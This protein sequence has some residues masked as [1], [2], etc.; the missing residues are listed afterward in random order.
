M[1][2]T[3]CRFCDI[4]NNSFLKSNTRDCVPIYNTV[5]LE[6]PNFLVLPALGS[7]IPGYLMIITRSH[8]NSMAY[9]SKDHM[10]ELI[11]LLS[12]LKHILMQTLNITPIIFEHGSAINSTEVAAN[13][14]DHAH[15]HVAP[16]NMTTEMDIL[17]ESQ[18]IKIKDMY[19]IKSFMGNPY[20]LYINE[21]NYFISHEVTLE[22]QFMRKW[23]AKEAGSAPMWD[24]REYEFLENVNYTISIL[25]NKL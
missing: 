20:F 21:N 10:D 16:I 19:E 22:R 1:E 17:N 18:A 15:V 2:I 14:V 25:K 11:D 13:S 9:L 5:L 7:I 3:D 12:Y 24:W 4:L 23:L 6:T 8:I